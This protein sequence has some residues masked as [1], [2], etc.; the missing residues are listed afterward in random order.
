MGGQGKLLNEGQFTILFKSNFL[1]EEYN[2][3]GNSHSLTFFCSWQASQVGAMDVVGPT[4]RAF[5]PKLEIMS[6]GYKV[7]SDQTSAVHSYSHYKS[8]TLQLAG[9]YLWILT[10]RPPLLPDLIGQ[11]LPSTTQEHVMIDPINIEK[12]KLKQ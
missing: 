5:T 9:K 10:K 12:L 8:Y 2:D 1:E 11:S 6:T 7:T 3:G 4:D